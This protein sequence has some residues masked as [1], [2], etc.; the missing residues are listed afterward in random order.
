[1]AVGGHRS[2]PQQDDGTILQQPVHSGRARRWFESGGQEEGQLA[3]QR[4][5]SLSPANP[6]RRRLQITRKPQAASAGNI[7]GRVPDVLALA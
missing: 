7:P 5:R 1:V 2:A 6:E 3:G 4:K